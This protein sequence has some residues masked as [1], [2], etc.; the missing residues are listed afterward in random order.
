MTPLRLIPIGSMNPGVMEYLALVL[1]ESTG[2]PCVRAPWV[3]N[4]TE[5]YL[6]ERG[7]YHSTRSSRP[8]FKAARTALEPAMKGG[9]VGLSWPFPFVE[10][11]GEP[12]GVEGHSISSP[13]IPR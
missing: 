9:P 8:G 5:A 11:R 1:P 6:N 3:I 7:Q 10:S 2:L 12:S 4:Y 13:P